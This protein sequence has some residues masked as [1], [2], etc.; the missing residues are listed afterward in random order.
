MPTGYQIDHPAETYFLTLT[1]VDWIDI[2]S[3]KIYRDILL[4]SLKYCRENKGLKIWGYAV[5]TNHMH[6]IFSAKNGNLPDVLRDMKRHTASKILKAINTGPESRKDWLLKRFEFA[7]KKNSRDGFYQF[8]THDNH[9]EEIQTHNFFMQK[10]TYIHM[11]PVR[12]GWVEKAEDW[13]YSS[14]RN[15]AGMPSLIDIDVSD[16]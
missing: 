4:D 16:A 13:L 5:M 9:A 7:A 8:W 11:N 3:R 10:L 1:V 15:Y 14:M 6:G 2:F 12:A